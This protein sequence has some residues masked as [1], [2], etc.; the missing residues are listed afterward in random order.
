MLERL[1]RLKRRQICSVTIIVKHRKVMLMW[2]YVF[3]I[4]V[5]DSSFLGPLSIGVPGE[6]RGYWAAHK[7][8]GKLPWKDVLQPTIDLCESGWNMSLHQH[9][10]V[11]A[12]KDLT[13]DDTLK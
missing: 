5:Y 3:I 7:R 9:D 10:S 12:N 13:K 8:F 2:K 11:R 6:L 1:R 4:F